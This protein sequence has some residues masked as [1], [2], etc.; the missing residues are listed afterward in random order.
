MAP[1]LHEHERRGRPTDGRGDEKAGAVVGDGVLL[2]GAV[3]GEIGLKHRR[4]R[5]GANSGR[6]IDGHRHQDARERQ[7]EQLRSVRPP[8]GLDAAARGDLDALAG[9][10]KG[11]DEHFLAR[12]MVSLAAAGLAA[13]P[14]P[15]S[16]TTATQRPGTSSAFRWPSRATP[17]RWAQT[18]RTTPSFRTA[19]RMC[20][21][22]SRKLPLTSS[23]AAFRTAST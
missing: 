15:W 20:L 4:R 3:G 13:S 14:R 17:W 6:R 11:H 7:V 9:R 5:A 21:R 8:P 1:A 16:S 2:D 18:K 23:P 19:P 12:A 22:R 10:R